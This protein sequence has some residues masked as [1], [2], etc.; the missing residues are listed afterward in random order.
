MDCP[1]EVVLL[2]VVPAVVLGASRGQLHEE[3]AP[4]LLTGVLPQQAVYLSQE[5]S[6]GLPQLLVDLLLVV[7]AVQQVGLQAGE[8][9]AEGGVGEIPDGGV[10]IVDLVLFVLAV[11]VAQPLP[12]LRL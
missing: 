12:V 2:P 1:V 8:G 4:V 3:P 10:P 5:P 7:E 11:E 6:L 9:E